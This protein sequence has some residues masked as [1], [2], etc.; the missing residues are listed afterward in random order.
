MTIIIKLKL[1][2]YKKIEE[3]NKQNNSYKIIW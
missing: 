2:K 1:I 3:T